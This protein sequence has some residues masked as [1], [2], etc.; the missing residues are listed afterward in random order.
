MTYADLAPIYDRIGLA[1]YARAMTPRLL[2]LAQRRDWMGRRVL[3]LGTGTGAAAIWFAQNNYMVTAADNDP[4]MMAV[5]QETAS[6]QSLGINF[7]ETHIRGLGG[8]DP[9]DLAIALDVMNTFDGLRELEG[10]FAHIHTL[11]PA[12]RLLIFDLHT[13]E[14]LVGASQNRDTI[15]YSEDDLAVF[16][17]TTFDYERQIQTVDYDIFRQ[18]GDDVW[19]RHS[20]QIIRRAFPLQVV[21]QLLR[22]QKFEVQAVLDSSLNTY[23]FGSLGE[24][25]V[26]FFAR[27]V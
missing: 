24:D 3:D 21:A 14:G 26:I 20:A 5:A 22:R 11:L 13:L 16:S 23:E 19:S 18:D 12:N 27:N 15:V 6:A 1:D 2:N 4:A 25:R 10:V 9:V 7:V 8:L 17:R